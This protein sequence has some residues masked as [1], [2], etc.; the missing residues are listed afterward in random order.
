[1]KR[2][3]PAHDRYFLRSLHQEI[4]L[5]DRKL[6]HLE[7]F[8]VFASATERQEA[9][10]H[11]LAKRDTLAR[12]AK[13]LAGAGVEFRESELPRSFRVPCDQPDADG[14]SQS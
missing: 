9:E 3:A 2:S 13:A 5:Y 8:E 6:A 10:K 7:K 11:I 1:M 12:T 4:D 14:G